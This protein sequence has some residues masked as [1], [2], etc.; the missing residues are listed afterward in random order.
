MK[1]I[2]SSLQ[3]ENLIWNPLSQLIESK[4]RRKNT[5][6]FSFSF[7]SVYHKKRIN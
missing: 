5:F 1:D 4:K 6:F 2:V 3:D 7:G